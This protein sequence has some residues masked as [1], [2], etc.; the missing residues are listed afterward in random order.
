M[1]R[2]GGWKGLE[3]GIMGARVGG[4]PGAR[5]RVARAFLER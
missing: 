4:M 5:Q 1:A 2:R 3:D